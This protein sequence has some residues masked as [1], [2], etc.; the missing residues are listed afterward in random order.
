[1][2]HFDLVANTRGMD[3][4]AKVLELSNWFARTPMTLVDAVAA[5]PDADLAY[6]MARSELDSLFGG[7]RDSVNSLIAF[8]KEGKPI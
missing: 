8:V 3:S 7:Q 6:A 4:C 1:M 2:A 5:N